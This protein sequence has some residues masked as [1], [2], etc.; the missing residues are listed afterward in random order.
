MGRIY[1][2]IDAEGLPGIF[3]SAQLTP[4]GF[5]FSELRDVMTRIVKAVVEELNNLGYREVW[6]ADSHGFMGNINYLDLP[7]NTVLIRGYLRPIPMV[8]AIDRGFDAAMF[9][10]YHSAA[11][12]PRSV[13]DHTFSGMAFSEVRIG[14]VRVS[15][16]YINAL[17]AGHYGVPVILVAGD[18]K[19][20]SEVEQRAPWATYVVLKESLSRWATI[21][22]SLNQVIEKLRQGVREAVDKLRKGEVSVVKASYPIDVEFVLRRTEFADAAETIPGIERVDAYTVRYRA[23]DPIE[24][25]KVMELLSLVAIAID[26]LAKM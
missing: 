4:K 3:H 22:S 2:S 17:V 1:I 9:I 20:R 19:L 13:F 10:G 11:G 26:T 8:T 14:G 5:L 16:F 6:V 18:D 7:P 23:R 15:E 24:L 25:Y 12:T 21:C